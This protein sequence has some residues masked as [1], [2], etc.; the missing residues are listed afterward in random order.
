MITRNAHYG[1]MMERVILAQ[2]AGMLPIG[3]NYSIFIPLII[4]PRAVGFFVY[5]HLD[6]VECNIA[7]IEV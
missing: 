5:R 6:P 1:S 3:S 4:N 2:V 7:K